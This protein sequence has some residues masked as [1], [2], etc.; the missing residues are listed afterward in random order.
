MYEEIPLNPLHF[1]NRSKFTT[2]KQLLSG[3]SLSGATNF[4]E[5]G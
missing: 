5:E 4:E 2:E 1:K 3:Y